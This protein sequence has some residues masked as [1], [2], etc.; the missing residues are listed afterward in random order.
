MPYKP[1][2]VS[3]YEQYI[4]LAGWRLEKGKIDWNL[5]DECENFICAIKIAHGKNTKREVVA[6][7]VKKTENAFKKREMI[8]P[9]LKSKN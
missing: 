8:W 7:S 1:L 3:R 4:K 5:Y 9:P 6:I 2:P